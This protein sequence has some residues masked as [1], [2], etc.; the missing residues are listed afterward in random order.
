MATRKVRIVPMSDTTALERGK[1]VLG[2]G[3]SIENVKGALSAQ[4][5]QLWKRQISEEELDHMLSWELCIVHEFLSD[6]VRGSEEARSAI[7][8]R[9]LVASFRWLHPTQTHD[10]WFVHGV[11]GGIEPFRVHEF[12]HCPGE[13]FLEDFEARSG[14]S[15]PEGFLEAGG[16]LDDFDRITSSILSTTFEFNPIVIAVRLSEQAYLD[17]HPEMRLLKRVMALEALFSSSNVYGKR[18]LIPRV[19]KFVGDKTPIYPGT[20]ASYTV[21]SVVGDMCDIR[22]AFAHGD[23]VPQYMLG[24]PPESA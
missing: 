22:N 8:T 1:I 13:V 23:V 21:G 6:L 3:F 15:R 14:L 19:S 16:F 18:A 2:H 10:G 24:T 12:S 11:P 7:M 20:A 4:S 9:F 5:F 17:F